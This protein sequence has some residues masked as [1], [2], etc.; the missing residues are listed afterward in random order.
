[1]DLM[2]KIVECDADELK[3][4]HDKTF[5]EA[6]LNQFEPRLQRVGQ[7]GRET[8][9]VAQGRARQ[10]VAPYRLV[11]CRRH[12]PLREALEN[13]LGVDGEP[14][15]MSYKIAVENRG[16]LGQGHAE[17]KSRLAFVI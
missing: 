7:V 6:G 9:C 10:T 8:H 11:K 14:P 17:R 16:R 12:L 4:I 5:V 3:R 2:F 15:V 1:G 13:Q